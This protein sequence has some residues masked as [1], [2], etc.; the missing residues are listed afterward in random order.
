MAGNHVV[1]SMEGKY[2]SASKQVW[3]ANMNQQVWQAK[4]TGQRL[5]SSDVAL[6]N[7]RA[8]FGGSIMAHELNCSVSS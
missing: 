7:F 1:A 4:T 6:A 3:Q 8:L 5:S 2:V